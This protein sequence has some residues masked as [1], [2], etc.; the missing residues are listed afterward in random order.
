MAKKLILLIDPPWDYSKPGP[1]IGKGARGHYPTMKTAA[2]IAF[3][4]KLAESTANFPNT[5]MFSWVTNPRLN[6]F[7]RALREMNTG[8][9]VDDRFRYSTKAFTWVKTNKD[10]TPFR[11]PGNFTASNEEGCYILSKGSVPPVKK[12]VPSVI[13]APKEEHSRKPAEARARIEEMYPLGSNYLHVELFARQASEG[14]VVF[15][16]EV[17][18][19]EDI[20]D[21]LEHL[22]RLAD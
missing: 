18:K 14:W 5:I 17:G 7:F 16:N 9:S 13:L 8:I 10:G 19:K 6:L 21:D 2:I 1:K 4:N 11:G 20:M 22:S 12:L 15:G 3:F